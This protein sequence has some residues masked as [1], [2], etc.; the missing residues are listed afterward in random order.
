MKELYL[1]QYADDPHSSKGWVLREGTMDRLVLD[2]LNRISYDKNS[3]V[4]HLPTD[5]ILAVYKKTEDRAGNI[6][7]V[8]QNLSE[9]YQRCVD[10]IERERKKNAISSNDHEDK[11]EVK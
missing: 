4:L 10:Y 8:E 2:P 5:T 11:P 3:D 1:F 6:I 9:F 7:W